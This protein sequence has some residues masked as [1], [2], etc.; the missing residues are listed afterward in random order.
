[1]RVFRSVRIFTALSLL[2]FVSV[3]VGA[4]AQEQ[5]TSVERKT[6]IVPFF[7]A[8][9]AIGGHFPVKCKIGDTDVEFMIDTGAS[10][11]AISYQTAVALGL[12]KRQP[13]R[14]IMAMT[15]S[16]ITPSPVFTLPEIS[17]GEIRIVNVVVTVLQP[18]I[19][20]NLLGNSFLTKL[21]RFE[22]KDGVLTLEQ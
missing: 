6:V 13:D 19:N 8:P 18:G 17:I 12:D 7:Q 1:M 5:Q 2:F 14:W 9:G 21:K 20:L 15:A 11:V 3:S 22:Y 10:G 4:C 16:G